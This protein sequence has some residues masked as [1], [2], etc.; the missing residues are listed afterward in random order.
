MGELTFCTDPIQAVRE[1]FSSRPVN[2]IILARVSLGWKGTEAVSNGFVTHFMQDYDF[3]EINNKYKIKNLR[4][5]L[6][7][8][9]ITVEQV[10]K[11]D[12]K[13]I[14]VVLSCCYLYSWNKVEKQ[15]S[16]QETIPVQVLPKS[17]PPD[18]SPHTAAVRLPKCIHTAK[19]PSPPRFWFSTYITDLEKPVDGIACTSCGRLAGPGSSGRYCIQCGEKIP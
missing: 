7:A 1:S 13:G 15:V 9:V 2:K 4:G 6:P 10:A 5:V 11:H 3:T 12:Q 18:F 8:F 14:C 16:H 17:P 19:F